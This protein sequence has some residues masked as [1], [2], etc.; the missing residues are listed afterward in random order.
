MGPRREAGVPDQAAQAVPFYGHEA[1]RG[2]WEAQGL[3]GAD[4][5]SHF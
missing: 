4:V 3:D 2:A 5:R 1:A